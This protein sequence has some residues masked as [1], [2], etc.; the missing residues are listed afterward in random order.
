MAMAPAQRVALAAFPQTVGV[1]LQ[2]QSCAPLF[3][4]PDQMSAIADADFVV[5]PHNS[6]SG[7]P[8]ATRFLVTVDRSDTLVVF[9]L[10][11]REAVCR[12][13]IGT[14][15]ST[16]SD[17]REGAEGNA[18]STDT[19]PC[20]PSVKGLLSVTDCT[21][22]LLSP[23]AHCD[24]GDAS[25]P[26]Y[27]ILV[28]VQCRNQTTSLLDISW[29]DGGTDISVSLVYSMIV[30]Q[31]GF[32][33]VGLVGGHKY[34]VVVA[35]GD[36]AWSPGSSSQLGGA[37]AVVHLIECDGSGSVTGRSL[38]KLCVA[39][40]ALRCGLLMS[41]HIPSAVRCAERIDLSVV[42]ATESGHAVLSAHAV[43]LSR[44][45]DKNT[46][47]A[48]PRF[49]TIRCS[50]EPLMS[51]TLHVDPNATRIGGILVCLSADGAIQ[52]HDVVL[53]S[54]ADSLDDTDSVGD[55][56]VAAPRLMWEIRREAT[57]GSNMSEALCWVRRSGA[58]A[59]ASTHAPIIAVG[60]WDSSIV[61]VNGTTGAVVTSLER[62]GKSVSVVR[63]LTWTSRSVQPGALPAFAKAAR[64]SRLGGQREAASSSDAT[65]CVFLSCSEDGGVSVWRL[66][67]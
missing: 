17:V 16:G 21:R 19:L 12:V 52:G 38:G 57:Q 20:R 15:E 47:T 59:E 23:L 39:D 7:D 8:S 62:H 30:P 63:R 2:T 41:L 42:A 5:P 4:L 44:S 33:K 46:G 14:I 64:V 6:S 32:C 65:S 55:G 27:R 60:S 45:H 66:T 10:E 3:T 43:S 9:D 22:W 1:A 51:A 36:V 31:F 28:L 37:H 13:C 54:T 58:S 11:L 24:I 34:V 40:A 49:V 56:G 48:A 50:A 26:R 53:R 61:V 29:R 67:L 18:D 25:A 35:P